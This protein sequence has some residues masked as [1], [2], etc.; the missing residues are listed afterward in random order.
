[1]IRRW[2]GY[3]YDSR[4]IPQI[5]AEKRRSDDLRVD[6]LSRLTGSISDLR[7]LRNLRLV[8]PLIRV[9]LQNLRLVAHLQSGGVKL[10]GVYSRSSAGMF[11][12]P[13]ESVM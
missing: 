10:W 13:G 11:L 12:K 9:Y 8:F 7:Y 5:Y 2:S 6:E 3:A 1:M 4:N